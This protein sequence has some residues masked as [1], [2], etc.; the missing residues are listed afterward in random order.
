MKTLTQTIKTVLAHL[1]FLFMALLIGGAVFGLF[2]GLKKKPLPQLNVFAIGLPIAIAAALLIFFL[3]WYLYYGR[4]GRRR[5]MLIHASAAIIF[6]AI[7][8]TAA[9][10]LVS[11]KK[12]PEKVETEVVAPLLQAQKVHAKDITVTV[13]GFGTVQAKTTVKIIPQVSGSITELHPNFVNGGFFGADETLVKI[14]QRDYR[15]AVQNAQAAVA[16]A[17]VA[18][19]REQAEAEVARREWEQL[20][21]GKEPTSPLV[22]RK[23]QIAEAQASLKAAK[24]QL[25]NAKLNLERTTIS[26]PF[27]GRVLEESVDIGQYVTA[28]QSIATVYGTDTVEI[29]VPLE[30]KQLQW[31]DVPLAG[32]SDD[33]G[34]PAVVTANFA[35]GT[36]TWDGRVVRTEGRIDPRSRMV[37][38]VVQVPQPFENANGRPPLQP[39][40]FVD[41][42]IIGKQLKNVIP[43]PR[44]ALHKRNELWIANDSRLHIKEVDII[45]MDKENAYISAGIPDGT[46]VI[47]D[48]LEAV[49]DNMKIRPRLT[50][51]SDKKEDQQ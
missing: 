18:L 1:Y 43:V 20:N 19:E 46:I 34:S 5:P 23:P 11:M 16:R 14:D 37:N 22:L 21:P 31:F 47:T 27:N 3:C 17:E 4:N 25:E 12:A 7:G 38:V 45:R 28:G 33:T 35:G 2:M 44:T 10:M 51:N 9:R 39:G 32:Q 49:T 8:L 48:S 6:I 29:T 13:S 26:L 15:N 36:H 50:D 40:V 24:A 41:V 42:D 30:D